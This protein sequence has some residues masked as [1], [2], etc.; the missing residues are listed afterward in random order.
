MQSLV[1]AAAAVIALVLAAVA[2]PALWVDTN[3]VRE[4]GFIALAAPLGEDSVFQERLAA[5]SVAA[6][7]PEAGLPAPLQTSGTQFL[8]GAAAKL[9]ADPG[10]PEAWE[11]TLRRSHRLNFP[12]SATGGSSAAAATENK[13]ARSSLTLDLTP[14]VTLLVQQLSGSVGAGFHAPEKVLFDIGTP[15]QRQQL[16]RAAAYT[17]LAWV[18]GVGAVVALGLSLVAARRRSAVAVWAGLGLMAV[19]GLWLL[20][21][22]PASSFAQAQAGSNPIAE[23]FTQTFLDAARADFE[24]WILITVLGGGGLALA[25]VAGFAATFLGPREASE[26]SS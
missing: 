22:G 18:P 11:E 19:A 6:L 15:G 17:P 7:T 16:E 24:R 26:R 2:V 3:I 20:G 9:S 8:M 1:S 5:A 21:I 23:L 25:G 14:L 10:Y 4:D 12:A 13:G